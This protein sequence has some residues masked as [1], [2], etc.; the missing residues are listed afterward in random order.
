MFSFKREEL[1][2]F[3][4]LIVIVLIC[5]IFYL[6]FSPSRISIK[7]IAVEKENHTDI[8]LVSD[9]EFVV[10]EKGKTNPNLIIINQ[11]SF[12][13]LLGCPGIGKQKAS[14]IIKERENSKFI[15]WRDFQN[16]IKGIASD[17]VDILIDAGV[18]IN[19]SDSVID[20]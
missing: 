20:L 12:E 16:R 10:V 17:Q 5:G 14:Q 4:I 18:R 8:K 2:G 6:F 3:R 9:D 19:A 1:I 13:E 11:S 15:D 7:K